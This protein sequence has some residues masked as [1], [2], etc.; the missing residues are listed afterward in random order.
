MRESFASTP[1]GTRTRTGAIARLSPN[2]V[3]SP[4]SLDPQPGI[5]NA[6]VSA[7]IPSLPPPEALRT[8]V[9]FMSWHIK[10][11]LFNRRGLGTPA[12]GC[13]H[14]HTPTGLKHERAQVAGDLHEGSGGSDERISG[15]SRPEGLIRP[16]AHGPESVPR[17]W[18][19][20][21]SLGDGGKLIVKG[22]C[23]AGHRPDIR[24]SD[25]CVSGLLGWFRIRVVGSGL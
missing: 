11:T 23:T 22:F 15:G 4:A 7:A 18:T 24:Y 16:K 14:G 20:S 10:R 19:R 12:V 21:P 8:K 5:P 25:L 13:N 17:G 2:V 6:R 9:G 3:G 1:D